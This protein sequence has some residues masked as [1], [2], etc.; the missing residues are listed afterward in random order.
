MSCKRALK[1]LTQETDIPLLNQ[2]EY[3]NE[4]NVNSERMLIYS[5]WRDIPG[6][7]NLHIESL[8]I[9]LLSP[10]SLPHQRKQHCSLR[11]GKYMCITGASVHNVRFG[12]SVD[13]LP[14]CS[15]SHITSQRVLW[16]LIALEYRL[17]KANHTVTATRTITEVLTFTD[18]AV[19]DKE[20]VKSV[21][22]IVAA[23]FAVLTLVL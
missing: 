10:F 6:H 19:T 14:V 20:G 9:T 7:H 23:L 5:S 2:A 3:E 21:V 12:S 11:K 1:L 17:D 22:S 13:E 18:Q 15:V 16:S 4:I 8:A